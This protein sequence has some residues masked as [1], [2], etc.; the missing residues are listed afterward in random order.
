MPPVTPR[1]VASGATVSTAA[2]PASTRENTSRPTLSVP[3]QWAVLGALRVSEAV[4]AWGSWGTIT[5]HSSASS[6]QKPT[7]PAPTRNVRDR[8]MARYSSRRRSRRATR[9]PSAVVAL[10]SRPA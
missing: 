6:T 8:R 7:T 9:T 4:I 1:S 3:N 5:L 10:T 2:A